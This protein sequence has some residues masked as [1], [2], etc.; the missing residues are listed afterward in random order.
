M[1]VTLYKTVNK[2]L[3]TAKEHN[4]IIQMVLRSLKVASVDVSVHAIGDTK[5][6]TLNRRY[7][8]KDKTTDVL[9]FPTEEHSSGDVGDLFISIPQ[10]K[11]QAKERN[12]SA[13]EEYTRMLVHGTLH[14]LGYDHATKKE[15]KEMFGLQEKFVNEAKK[16][17]L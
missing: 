17:Y 7:M 12:I 11:R 3:L 16:Q 14:L 10:I 6:R 2:G 1:A 5:M 4:Q 15:E 9:S 8:G 13:R